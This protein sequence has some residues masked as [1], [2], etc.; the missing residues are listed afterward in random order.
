MIYGL[1]G[2]KM[3]RKNVKELERTGKK[4]D[5]GMG[6]RMDERIMN[7]LIR[8]IKKLDIDSGMKMDK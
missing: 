4:M 2:M 8:M 6:I 1:N 7:Q 3:G 5:Y